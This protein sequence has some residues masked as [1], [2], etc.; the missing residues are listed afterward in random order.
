MDSVTRAM[1]SCFHRDEEKEPF[2]FG[3][4]V[5]GLGHPRH[6]LPSSPGWPWARRA[7]HCLGC[8]YWL[9]GQVMLHLSITPAVVPPARM[10]R[11]GARRIGWW[12]PSRCRSPAQVGVSDGLGP[13]GLDVLLQVGPAELD[14]A[15]HPVI[16]DVPAQCPPAKG[17]L[18]QGVLGGRLNQA[19]P[20]SRR[21][22]ADDGL[23]RRR[24]LVFGV[25]L[26]PPVRRRGVC[27]AIVASSLGEGGQTA[28]YAA[29]ASP[30]N[31]PEMEAQGG[32]WAAM[33]PVATR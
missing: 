22:P 2:D 9:A 13:E 3:V 20:V 19:Q 18:A 31:G 5:L 17:R 24:A 15:G 33:G 16:G 26:W 12:R 1:R 11:R 10:G 23:A 28:V 4:D 21:G 25:V 32:A 27:V 6:R 14:T 30:V 7:G 29:M 8:H